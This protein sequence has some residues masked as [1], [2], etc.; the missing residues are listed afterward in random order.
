M[1]TEFKKVLD[2]LDELE[3]EAAK[4]RPLQPDAFLE[5]RFAQVEGRL[6]KVDVAALAVRLGTIAA[7]AAVVATGTVNM[8]AS[9]STGGDVV[10]IPL[11]PG[12]A[13]VFVEGSRGFV[14]EYVPAGK[15]MLAFTGGSEVGAGTDMTSVNPLDVIV[16]GAVTA[17]RMVWRASEAGLVEQ[18]D[19]E[20]SETFVPSVTNYWTLQLVRYDADDV[21]E[22]LGAPLAL[23]SRGLTA[24][25]AQTLYAPDELLAL[26]EGD[27]LS[28]EIVETGTP[29]YLSELTVWISTRR[30]TA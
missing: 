15:K 12:T 23:S 4:P 1:T 18:A 29:S 30:R 13:K 11:V 21:R 20:V 28:L 5:S 6:E 3:R 27:T 24:F 16:T 17:E 22:E 19:V 26:A 7:G 9:Y 14:F 25:K 10:T 8:S 2:R